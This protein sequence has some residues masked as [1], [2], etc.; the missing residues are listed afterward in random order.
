M[1]GFERKK[2][3]RS[4][5]EKFIGQSRTFAAGRNRPFNSG[6]YRP[7]NSG[8]NTPV[9]FPADPAEGNDDP[10]MNDEDTNPYQERLSGQLSHSQGELSSFD[11]PAL[12]APHIWGT[13]LGMKFGTSYSFREFVRLE[14]WDG[15]RQSGKFWFRISDDNPWHFTFKVK[16]TDPL[17]VGSPYPKA[18]VDDGSEQNFGP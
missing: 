8:I 7:N 15:K 12:S 4:D 13:V 16:F 5:L 14:I 10:S 3:R 6:N 18:W 11:A 2:L 9:N 17:P 1:P